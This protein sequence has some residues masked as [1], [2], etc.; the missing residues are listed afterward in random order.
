MCQ[1]DFAVYESEEQCQALCKH[2][3]IGENSD[4]KGQNTLGC[5]KYHTYNAMNDPVTHCPH[6]GPGGAGVCGDPMTGNCDSYCR[7]SKLAC[8]TEFDA[9]FSSDEDCLAQCAE[10]DPGG[11]FSVAQAQ[12]E[13]A[14]LGCRFLALSRAA[15][16]DKLCPAVFGAA[17]CE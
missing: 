3:A 12:L 14:A 7:I 15:E 11:K 5:R 13:P 1:D 17:P 10:L 9:T 8:G 4:T 6:L 2:F 16:D